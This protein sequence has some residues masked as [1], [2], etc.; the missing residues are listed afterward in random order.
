MSDGGWQSIRAQS[1]F[2]HTERL[3]CAQGPN[4]SCQFDCV[5][6]VSEATLHTVFTR[7]VLCPSAKTRKLAVVWAL[8]LAPANQAPCAEPPHCA[9][10]LHRYLRTHRQQIVTLQ[11]RGYLFFGTSVDILEAIHAHVKV[12][13]KEQALT[14]ADPLLGH[15][16][17]STGISSLSAF[18]DDKCV[19]A[20]PLGIPIANALRGR[21]PV[22]RYA[23]E[24]VHWMYVDG[25]G[26]VSLDPPC[27]RKACY[28]ESSEK[29][30]CT[31]CHE[32]PRNP[33]MCK[34]MH[35]ERNANSGTPH[36]KLG[37]VK[38]AKRACAHC[39]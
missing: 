24:K 21:Y 38:L 19:R 1:S 28:G 7:P 10:L 29:L 9:W 14:E 15:P 2:S 37:F 23:Y 35:K 4:P 26:I 18:P 33:T 36:F 25:M 13:N 34:W 11:L 32:V 20:L 22:M 8:F 5:L 39:C 17:R 30:P 12:P 6:R 31:P 27:P 3:T 16:H